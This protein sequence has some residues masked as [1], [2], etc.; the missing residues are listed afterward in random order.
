MS[1]ANQQPDWDKIAEKFDMWLPHIAPVTD[2]LLF[3]LRATPEHRILDVACGTGEPALTLA[4]LLGSEAKIIGA[5]SAEGMIRVA[6]KKAAEKGLANLHFEVM[7]AEKLDFAD[8]SFD[9]VLCRFGV[10][11]FE[12]PLQGLREMQRV[13]RP[14]GRF[15]LAVW[16]TPELMPIMHWSYRVFASRLKEENLPALGKITSMSGPGVLEDHLHQAGFSDFDI[17]T[18]TL[19]YKFNSF[20]EFWDTIEA[21]DILKQQF[22]AIDDNEKAKVRDEISDFAAEFVKEG[23]LVV[24]HEYLLAYGI[25]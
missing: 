21:S 13:L 1:T 25:K 16:S 2:E 6:R 8:N 19:N 17:E 7:P 20:D 15:A 24:P 10:M 11:L 14:D 23:K 22:D 12:D 18:R 5:D 4:R 9:R 3:A